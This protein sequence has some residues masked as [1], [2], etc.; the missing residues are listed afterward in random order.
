MIDLNLFNQSFANFLLAENLPLLFVFQVEKP[1]GTS[2]E[3][4]PYNTLTSLKSGET[5]QES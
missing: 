5:C 3:R 4:K 2:V 1:M